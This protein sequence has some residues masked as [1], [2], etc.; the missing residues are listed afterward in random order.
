MPPFPQ[1]TAL[2]MPGSPWDHRQPQE[3]AI[4]IAL[5]LP[6][7]CFSGLGIADIPFRGGLNV[8]FIFKATLGKHRAQICLFG[9][10]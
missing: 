8:L 5:V 1:G 2:A 10:Q 9:S 4:P 3:G 6:D 7:H